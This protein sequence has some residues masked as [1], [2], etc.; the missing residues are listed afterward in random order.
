VTL[1]LRATA[2]SS[3]TVEAARRWASRTARWM[4]VPGIMGGMGEKKC[5]RCGEVKPLAE[6]S[7]AAHGRDGR[8]ADCKQCH[9]TLYRLP[10]DRVPVL[11]CRYC[12][13]Q[14]PN[15]ARRGPDREF[16]STHCKERWWREEYSRRRQ[17]APPRP[18]ERCGGPVAH[19]TGLPVCKDCRVDDRSRPY[20]RATILKSR[21]GITL[22][23]YDRM[24]A[25]QDGRCAICGT[26]EPG[27]PGEWPVDHDRLTG[28][29]RGLL[30]DACN[31][32]IGKLR[33]DP[34]ILMAAARYLARHRQE[35]KGGG[36][37]PVNSW[38][39]LPGGHPAQGD[40]LDVLRAKPGT[41]LTV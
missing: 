24:L 32:G 20:R 19:K 26:T 36:Q 5:S 17:A 39:H 8:A 33:H 34:E 1:A 25:E 31:L 2:R 18:C 23:D 3:P 10:L 14:F 6:F 13:K 7:R 30:C 9:N 37:S 15:P 16:C 27:R 41:S 38:E 21:Y 12:G 22:A 40:A 11:T 35:G 28:H 4:A 29:V